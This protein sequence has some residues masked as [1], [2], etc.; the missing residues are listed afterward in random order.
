[1]LQVEQG[2]GRLRP[3]IDSDSI[4]KDIFNNQDH[5]KDGKIVED[6]LTP[7]VVEDSEQV[8]RDEL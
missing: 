2:N 3:G 1:M 8:K 6:E 4:I 5:N 7:K